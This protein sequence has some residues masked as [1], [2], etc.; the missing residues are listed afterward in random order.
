M[1]PKDFLFYPKLFLFIT[2][3][4]FQS[5][6][7]T[8]T[9]KFAMGLQAVN[10]NTYPSNK[11]CC[12]NKTKTKPKFSWLCHFQQFKDQ[13][14][15]PRANL[16]SSKKRCTYKT[17]QRTK[18]PIDKTSQGQ[19]VPRDKTS[20]GQNIPKTKRPKGKNV[21]RAKISQGTNEAHY[22]TWCGQLPNPIWPG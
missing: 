15:H 9:K 17:S 4:K 11:Y 6:I 14:S 19:N 21:P 3:R 16:Y 22:L 20:Q 12:F 5:K 18:R 13:I 2:V 8:K 10:N 1:S 7:F